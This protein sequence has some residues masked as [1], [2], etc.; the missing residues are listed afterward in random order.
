MNLTTS[1]GGSELEELIIGVLF[2]GGQTSGP[3]AN[4]LSVYLDRVEARVARSGARVTGGPALDFRGHQIL[5]LGTVELG[6]G[7]EHVT[8]G[9]I[10][11]VCGEVAAG[12]GA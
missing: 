3:Y 6:E 2:V 9:M 8:T 5:K 7:H 4:A 10:V 12:L 11:G 1:A